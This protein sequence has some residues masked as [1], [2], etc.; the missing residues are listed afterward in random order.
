[1]ILARIISIDDK[2]MVA[3]R[4]PNK[5]PDFESCGKFGLDYYKKLLKEY[6]ETETIVEVEN[7]D[8]WGDW[9][10]V[11]LDDKKWPTAELTIGQQVFIESTENNKCR[12]IKI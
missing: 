5:K 4:D 7:V 6:E 9:A 10:F 8:F 11:R 2:V 1:M 12:I 3:Y